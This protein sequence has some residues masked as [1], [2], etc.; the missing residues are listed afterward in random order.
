MWF[1]EDLA[2]FSDD[3]VML[4]NQKGYDVVYPTNR[5]PNFSWI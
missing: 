4:L 2:A 5:L 3:E 1:Y